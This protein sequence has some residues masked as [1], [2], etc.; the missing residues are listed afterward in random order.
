MLG[1][2]DAL[3]ACAGTE[4]ED[5]DLWFPFRIAQAGHQSNGQV[6]TEVTSKV[7]SFGGSLTH[8]ELKVRFPGAARGA[9]H[10]AD[11]LDQLVKMLPPEIAHFHH[12]CVSYNP[13][14][15]GV[16]IHFKNGS[17]AE[18]DVVIGADGIKS[19]VRAH[20]YE[21][22]GLPKSAQ[23]ARYSEWVAW[24]G[25][26][27]KTQFEEAMGVGAVMKGNNLAN[28]KHLLVSSHSPTLGLAL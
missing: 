2:G 7:N 24:R 10:R 20:I 3:K 16:T 13:H 28:D 25:L 1:L 15:N 6:F 26:V 5:G 4:F 12:R 11:F 9:V 8:H 19:A 21:R 18:A 23:A 17:M 22:K 14:E 27:T